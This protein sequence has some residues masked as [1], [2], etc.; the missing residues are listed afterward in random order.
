MV[1]IYLM[2]INTLQHSVNEQK[3]VMQTVNVDKLADLQD[4]M[5]DMKF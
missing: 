3:K 2:Q 1:T 5:M 4:D